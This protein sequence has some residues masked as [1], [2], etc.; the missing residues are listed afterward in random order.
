MRGCKV[1]SSEQNF[2][3]MTRVIGSSD[4]LVCE[5][6]GTLI[7]YFQRILGVGVCACNEIGCTNSVEVLLF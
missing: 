5:N 2:L 1:R 7:I 6:N 3:E 4:L